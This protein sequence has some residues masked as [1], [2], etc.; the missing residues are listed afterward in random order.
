ML[1]FDKIYSLL[2]CTF[3]LNLMALGGGDSNLYGYVGHD[4]VNG[5]DPN[6][7]AQCTYSI[8][9]HLLTCTSGNN[10]LITNLLFSGNGD[11]KNNPTDE[12]TSQRDRGAVPPDN[13]NISANT[14]LGKEGW[15]G[16][17]ST[18]WTPIL[19]GLSYKVGWTRAGFN[20]HTGSGSQG[21]LTFPK[22]N[23]DAV[24]MF[25]Q[26]SSIFSADAPNNTISVGK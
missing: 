18:S 8:G 11:C 2:R 12:C 17:Q 6:G 9:N 5:I 22:T 1:E 26:V 23:K 10:I 3:G 7:L 19:S 13:Y 21:C 16:L 25:N 15:W 4:P 24:D 20:F 14:K